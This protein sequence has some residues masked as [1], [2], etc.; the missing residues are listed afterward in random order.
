MSPL[1][2]QLLLSLSF[3]HEIKKPVPELSRCGLRLHGSLYDRD[4][5]VTINFTTGRVRED[6][7]DRFVIDRFEEEDIF[8]AFLRANNPWRR[9]ALAAAA[10][11]A[12]DETLVLLLLS[13]PISSTSSIMPLLASLLPRMA[14]GVNISP[15]SSP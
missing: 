1:A 8:V 4:T 11:A 9:A 7:D 12:A 14:S 10:A 5:L 2:L 13:S 6:D 15:A 3:S